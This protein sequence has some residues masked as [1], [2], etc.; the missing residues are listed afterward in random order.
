MDGKLHCFL[1]LQLVKAYLTVCITESILYFVSVLCCFEGPVQRKKPSYGILS[2]VG[3]W[4]YPTIF[5]V[6]SLNCFWI[7][8]VLFVF[9]IAVEFLQIKKGNILFYL[10]FF[11]QFFKDLMHSV[12]SF[13]RFAIHEQTWNGPPST[14]PLQYSFGPKGTV[15]WV[16]LWVCFVYLLFFSL[17]ANKY[18]AIYIGISPY[19]CIWRLGSHSPSD[20][21]KK[22]MSGNKL[23]AFGFFGEGAV[24][25]FFWFCLF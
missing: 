7:V 6:N 8:N 13:A 5:S 23:V 3:H 18:N 9:G 22:C 16:N 25:L 24:G 21:G 4:T 19:I 2:C 17:A 10:F 11:L 15:A 12:W 20:G 14:L 1:F